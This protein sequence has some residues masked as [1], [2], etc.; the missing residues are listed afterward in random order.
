MFKSKK[1]LLAISL[2]TLILN[3]CASKLPPGA[4]KAPVVELCA[5]VVKES[6]EPVSPYW[7]CENTKTRVQT[8]KPIEFVQIGVSADDWRELQTS[9]RAFE[10]WAWELY[11]Q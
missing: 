5:L 6:G 2:M 8:K 3:A 7:I 9:R 11:R 10:K 4:P 1:K